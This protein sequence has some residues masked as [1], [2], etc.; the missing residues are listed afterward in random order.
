MEQTVPVFISIL[1]SKSPRHK[2]VKIHLTSWRWQGMELERSSHCFHSGS[3]KDCWHVCLSLVFSGNQPLH[4]SLPP[5]LW[6][7]RGLREFQRLSSESLHFTWEERRYPPWS[8]VILLS[9]K[10]P[11]LSQNCRSRLCS[12]DPGRWP[13]GFHLS[14]LSLSHPFSSFWLF[15]HFHKLYLFFL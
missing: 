12:A 7:S 9:P 15:R 8:P 14:A 13:L 6:E 10:F 5:G 2:E 4:L 11:D 1:K 3:S